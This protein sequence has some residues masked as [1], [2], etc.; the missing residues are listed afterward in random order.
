MSIIKY[1]LLLPLALIS[2]Q[3]QGSSDTLFRPALRIGLDVGGFAR[4]FVEP[5]VMMSEVSADV[6]W[7]RGFFAAAEFGLLHIDVEKE[8][9][10]YQARGNFFRLGSDFNI[11]ERNPQSKHDVLLLSVRYG[12]GWMEHEAPFIIISDPFWGDY[13]SL[14]ESEKYRA[15]WLEAGFGL[16]TELWNNIFVGWSL[17]GHL[18]ISR[19]REAEMEPHFISGFGRTNGSTSLLLH[20]QIMYRIPLR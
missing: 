6:E 7:R 15:H 16:R 1:I 17:R 3:V 12:F 14:V 8:T 13:E 9:H 20:Y 18:L 11:L 4:K 10:R 19:T 2:L 5:E